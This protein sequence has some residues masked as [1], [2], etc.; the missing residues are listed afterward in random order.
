MPGAPCVAQPLPKRMRSDGTEREV[1]GRLI[2]A[3]AW[4]R[5]KP[6]L[7][8]GFAQCLQPV[9]FP[10]TSARFL[11]PRAALAWLYR[12][13]G[14][15]TCSDHSSVVKSRELTRAAEVSASD[16]AKPRLRLMFSRRLQPIRFRCASNARTH[17]FFA[18]FSFFFSFFCCGVSLVLLFFAFFC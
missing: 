14:F 17:F 16:C 15:M 7:L 4:D 9:R 5:A 2:E 13:H 6:R 10:C 12:E 8:F 1:T 11:A 3:T 18:D